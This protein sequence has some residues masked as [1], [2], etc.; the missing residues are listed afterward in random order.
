MLD[1]QIH[2]VDVKADL[3]AAQR[4]ARR[5]VLRAGILAELDRLED[6]ANTPDRLI[7]KFADADDPILRTIV[8]V[9]RTA[10]A[11]IELDE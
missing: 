9:A 4:V 7:E 5:M 6:S 1:R 8:D 10:R 2:D 3:G 11:E